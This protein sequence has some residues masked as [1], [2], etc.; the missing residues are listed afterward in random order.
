MDPAMAREIARQLVEFADEI[1][2]EIANPQG[3]E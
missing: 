3:V 1:D 2:R